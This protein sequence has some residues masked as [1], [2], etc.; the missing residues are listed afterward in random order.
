MLPQPAPP[1]SRAVSGDAPMDRLAAASDG[2]TTRRPWCT[3]RMPSI[4]CSAGASLTMYP[5]APA[6]IARRR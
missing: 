3:R 1:I 6:S 4:S 5:T 2:S